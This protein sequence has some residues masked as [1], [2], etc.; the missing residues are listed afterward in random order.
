M[1]KETLQRG[2]LIFEDIRSAEDRVREIESLCEEL[3]IREQDSMD[4]KIQITIGNAPHMIAD[5][6]DL[7]NI[8]DKEKKALL[9][10]IEALKKEFDNLK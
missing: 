8:A 4:G 5:K 3:D 7:L 10:K 9:D 2:N 1:K 6:A